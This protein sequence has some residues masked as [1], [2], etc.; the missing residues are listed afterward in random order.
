MK[1][2]AALGTTLSAIA[3]ISILYLAVLMPQVELFS[4][5]VR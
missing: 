2:V 3:A 1:T 5:I 4:R